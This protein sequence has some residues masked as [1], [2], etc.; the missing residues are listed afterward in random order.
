M[1]N[2]RRGAVLLSLALA[3]S[4]VPVAA[5][6]ASPTPEDLAYQAY[7]EYYDT[8]YE[9]YRT[10]SDGYSEVLSTIER[11]GF[12]SVSKKQ[13]KR[14]AGPLAEQLAGVLLSVPPADCYRDYSLGLWVLYG[15]LRLAEDW[16]SDR[17]S[18]VTPYH[19]VVPA[20]QALNLTS[21]TCQE[22]IDALQ[23]ELDA[24]QEEIDALL[25]E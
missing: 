19:F 11:D 15:S 14:Q 10:L 8:V 17:K 22:E 9:D 13:T 16:K 21:T 4:D 6:D 12:F 25:E 2:L 20:L 7:V 24:L 23:E 1:R 3:L 5:Q 18:S